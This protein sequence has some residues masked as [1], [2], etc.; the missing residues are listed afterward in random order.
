MQKKKCNVNQALKLFSIHQELPLFYVLQSIICFP[1]YFTMLSN[2]G[3]DLFLHE[4]TSPSTVKKL[5]TFFPYYFNLLKSFE[6]ITGL[7][8]P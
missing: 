8:N 7:N 1:A 4:N 2:S 5:Y 3:T 6:R